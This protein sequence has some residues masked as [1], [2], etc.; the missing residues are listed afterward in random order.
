M[1]EPVPGVT[2]RY[3]VSYTFEGTPVPQFDDQFTF[4]VG[5]DLAGDWTATVRFWNS[6]Y[7]AGVLKTTE[8]QPYQCR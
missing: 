4:A 1:T 5:P 7:N 6:K 8:R 3:T 2:E